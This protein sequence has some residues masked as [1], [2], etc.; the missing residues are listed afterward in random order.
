MT[1]AQVVETSVCHNR[2]LPPGRLQCIIIIICYLL[3]L[4]WLWQTRINPQA[5]QFQRDLDN[6]RELEYR[7]RAFTGDDIA[8]LARAKRSPTKNRRNWHIKRDRWNVTDDASFSTPECGLVWGQN[9]EYLP[10]KSP[11]AYTHSICRIRF[12]RLI[13][14]VK[15]SGDSGWGRTLNYM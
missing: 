14:Y 13:Y 10:H 9:V 15:K 4:C 11:I 1:S 7:L 2:L 5:R 3:S 8:P 12:K 6:R